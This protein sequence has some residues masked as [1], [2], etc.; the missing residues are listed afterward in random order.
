M[1]PRLVSLR[2]VC[3]TFELCSQNYKVSETSIPFLDDRI[4]K[5]LN[6][7]L[8]MTLYNK[9]TNTLLSPL[10]FKSPQTSKVGG[11]YSQLL[12]VRRIWTLLVDFESNAK[13][14]IT[15]PEAIQILS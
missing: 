6:G 14:I 9:L 2:K 12:R 5:G 13:L 11:P 15:V 8:Y 3:H 7:K 4:V 10:Q 1:D